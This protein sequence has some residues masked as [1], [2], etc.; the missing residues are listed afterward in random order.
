MQYATSIMV[1]GGYEDDSDDG[2]ELIYTGVWLQ[3]KRFQQLVAVPV[4][5]YAKPNMLHS[6][7]AVES[8]AAQHF[9]L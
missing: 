4:N 2:H 6:K 1:C 5:V 7:S 9:F 3:P 8:E